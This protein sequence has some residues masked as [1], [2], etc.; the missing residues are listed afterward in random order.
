MIIAIFWGLIAVATVI[1]R[2][3]V[4]WVAF[5]FA[6][7]NLCVFYFKRGREEADYETD[8]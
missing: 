4:P 3:S 5:L 2:T 8:Y 1:I 7:L 6:V